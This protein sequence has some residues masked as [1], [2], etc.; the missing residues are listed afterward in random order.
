MEKKI[1]FADG[2]RGR[3]MTAEIA[4]GISLS[5]GF[6]KMDKSIAEAGDIVVEQYDYS[7]EVYEALGGEWC[8]VTLV[9][10]RDKPALCQAIRSQDAAVEEEDDWLV[11]HFLGR[12]FTNRLAL[13]DWL[14]AHDIPFRQ[15]HDSGYG[16]AEDSR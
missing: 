11:L 14:S 13:N 2:Q 8:W 10:H 15:F 3:S 16:L 9:S 7:T 12:N 6:V 5:V 4:D 1:K